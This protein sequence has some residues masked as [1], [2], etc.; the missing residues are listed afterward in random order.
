[1]SETAV[2]AM[3]MAGAIAAMDEIMIDGAGAGTIFGGSSTNVLSP[4]TTEDGRES[5][6]YR[7]GIAGRGTGEV[8]ILSRN[9]PPRLKMDQ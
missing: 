8:R 3:A 2:L 4:E 7:E 5:E 1:M 9:K 6:F